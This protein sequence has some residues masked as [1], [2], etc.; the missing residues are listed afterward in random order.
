MAGLPFVLTITFP[1]LNKR[2]GSAGTFWLYAA[3]CLAGFVFILR[4]LRDEEGDAGGDR[5]G[6]GRSMT[7]DGF[8]HSPE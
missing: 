4:R 2:L 1:V 7:D 8:C 5:D 3:I 6:T